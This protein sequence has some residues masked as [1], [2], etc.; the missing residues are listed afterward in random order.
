MSKFL[1]LMLALLILSGCTFVELTD[2]GAEVQ[3]ANSV[4]GNCELKGTTTT[5]SRA[6]VAGIERNQ[7]KFKKELQILARNQAATLRGNLVV[8][9]GPVQGNQR[10]YQVFRCP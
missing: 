2:E 3:V 10:T 8:P 5:V 9:A 1:S 7:E 4:A 6:S